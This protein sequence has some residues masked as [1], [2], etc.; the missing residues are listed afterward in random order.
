MCDLLVHLFYLTTSAGIIDI[1]HHIQGYMLL[2]IEHWL[3][4]ILE[5]HKF[6]YIPKPKCS[7]PP[8][9]INNNKE[10]NKEQTKAT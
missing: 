7:P 3:S 8:K 1:Y 6:P 10:T 2:G 4:Y 5:T 9:K